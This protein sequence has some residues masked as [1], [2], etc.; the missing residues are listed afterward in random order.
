MG[1]PTVL[2]YRRASRTLFL[3]IASLSFASPASYA[4]AVYGSISGVITDTQ[5]A[6]MPGVTVT[7]TS[8]ERQTPDIVVTNESG[9]YMKDRLVPGKYE[10]KAELPGFK[11]A[12]FSDVNVSVDTQTQLNMKSDIGQVS[13]SV[14]VAG[15]SPVLKTDRA[16]VA[17]TFDSQPDHRPAG[18]RSQ[19]HEAHP[20]D[21]RHAAAGVAARREREPAGVDA[22]DGQRAA[23]QRNRLPARRHREPRSDSRHHRHQPELRRDRGNQDHFAELRRGIRA[24]HGRRRLGADQVGIERAARRGVRVPSRRPSPG[25]Q[26]VHAGA[27][28]SAYRQVHSRHEP[29]PVRRR[30]SAVRSRR[31]SCSS[32][33]TI[34]ACA[35]TSAAPSC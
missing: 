32:S 34:R 10:V 18:A 13:E 25:A 19:L 23:F 4:Q 1:N 26:S 17:T 6:V 33:A 20:A 2:R 11:S 29:Q 22:D 31:T 8:V 27:A 21:A 5:G 3:I 28:G 7:V 30:R 35:A 15:F 12:V 24:G 16:D 14:T 9:V